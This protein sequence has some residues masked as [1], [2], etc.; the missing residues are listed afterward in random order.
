MPESATRR[1]WFLRLATSAALGIFGLGA[2]I[3]Q[4]AT[5]ATL[6]ERL[7]FGLKAR[8]PQEFEF[9]DMIVALVDEGTLPETV[10]NASFN[11]ARHQNTKYPYQYFVR[12]IRILGA[13]LGI[14]IPPSG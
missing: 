5:E 4:A 1:Q 3:G 11:W 12:A 6:R 13:R 10:V 2:R 8:R 9:I 7:V 14:D